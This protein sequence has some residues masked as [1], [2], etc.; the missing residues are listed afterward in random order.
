MTLMFAV[1]IVHQSTYGGAALTL[2]EG[3][4][5]NLEYVYTDGP[6][7]FGPNDGEKGK[8]GWELLRTKNGKAFGCE[9]HV[10]DRYLHFQAGCENFDFANGS[11][12][13]NDNSACLSI[14]GDF[15]PWPTAKGIKFTNY[16]FKGAKLVGADHGVDGAIRWWNRS[17]R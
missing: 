5:F 17:R 3:D 14:D 10:R 12:I 15:G 1:R 7:G 4:G 11:V 9:F 6:V 8:P 13:A 2:K 16:A